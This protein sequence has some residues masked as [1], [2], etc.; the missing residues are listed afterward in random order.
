MKKP[1]QH[2]QI[3]L[4][5]ITFI[6]TIS[7]A[8]YATDYK[9]SADIAYSK[10]DW[11]TAAEYYEKYLQQKNSGNK[12]SSYEPYTIQTTKKST[13]T[14]N[15][16][17]TSA[18]EIN[19]R[20][21]ESYRKLY[22]YTKAEPYYAASIG[23]YPLAEYYYGVCLRAN[24]KY[25]EAEKAFSNF[26]KTYTTTDE[27]LT[28]A[29]QEKENCQYI[30]KELGKNVSA[31]TVNK[32]SGNTN[33]LGSNYAP[34]YNGTQLTFTS[35]RPDSSVIT[36]KNKNPFV[37]NIYVNNN[38]SIEKLALSTTVDY[39]QGTASFTQDGKKVYFTRWKKV[40]GNLQSAIYRSDFKNGS[41][42]EPVKLGSNVNAEGFNAKQPFV[43]ADGKYL[44]YASNRPNGLGKYDIWYAPLN[45]DG[46][47]GSFHNL[48]IINSTGDDE[49]P[50]YSTAVNALIFATNGRT[51]MGGFDLFESKGS[52]PA[53]FTNPINLGYPVNSVKDDIYFVHNSNEKLLQNVIISTDRGSNCCLELYTVNREYKKFVTGVV[54][55][56]KT[57][58]PLANATITA[59]EN[60]NNIIAQN[61]DANGT[62][63]FEVKSF[64]PRTLSARKQDYDTV[65]TRINAP[66]QLSNYYDDTLTAPTLC[67]NAI[68]KVVPL[69]TP[70]TT[71]QPQPT[72]E[73]KN[74]LFDFAKYSLR[75]ETVT[76]LD[77][78]AALMKRENKIALDI[79]GYTD[80]VGS[81]NYNLRLS[82]ERANACKSYL[83]NKGI[84]A[85]RI[86]AIGKGECCPVEPD[87]INGKDNPDGRQANRRVEFK[88]KLLF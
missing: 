71:P 61:T 30:Q 60:N 83:V 78:L 46:D 24:A 67:L 14:K 43:T 86:T 48:T 88:L 3:I 5:L 51:G 85:N 84:A 7:Y 55:D 35:S 18:D 37:N 82:Q 47:P 65:N 72:A 20:I 34:A 62:Y 31:Y 45:N 57:N 25:A 50:Y 38:N 52:L 56:C 42:S 54:K 76:M 44:L 75:K 32:L 40:D 6:Y 77:T 21:A 12:N 23:K 73:E 19:Y 8:Q 41:W 11:F 27:F 17:T 63:I 33:S 29:K 1:F 79:V 15:N 70:T 13:K 28:N 68:E 10:G 53:N 80:N 64:V 49:A 74:A 36:K 87:T 69:D 59:T 58:L 81:S 16:N 39:E 4:T 9:R 2:K 26:I 22:Y 66:L